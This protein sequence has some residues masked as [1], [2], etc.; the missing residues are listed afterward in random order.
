MKFA[1]AYGSVLDALVAMT[2]EQRDKDRAKGIH[3]LF[4][5]NFTAK[6]VSERA[7]CS[8]GTARKHL[9]GLA[10]CRDFCRT[11]FPGGTYGYR[12]YGEDR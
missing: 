3:G 6:A 11:R 9:E 1:S 8:E 12:Y 4:H 10:R 5:H 7:G 2:M